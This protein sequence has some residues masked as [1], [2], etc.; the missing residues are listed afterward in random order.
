MEKAPTTLQFSSAHQSALQELR[1]CDYGRSAALDALARSAAAICETDLAAVM[2]VEAEQIVFAAMCG[3]SV[4]RAPRVTPVCADILASDEPFLVNDV[5]TDARCSQ[6][7]PFLDSLGVRA[8]AVTQIGLEPGVNV[9]AICVYD[10][11]PREW[12]KTQ[13]DALK[14]LSASAAELLRNAKRFETLSERNQVLRMSEDLA[15][16]GHW[17]LNLKNN[18][19]SWS[20]RVYDIHGVTRAEYAP[21]LDTAIDYYHPDDRDEIARLAKRAVEHGE[22]YSTRLRI[23]RPDGAVRVIET[24]GEPQTGPDGDVIA[25][26]GVFSDV[27]DVYQT[28]RDLEALVDTGH[29]GYWEWRATG[30]HRINAR[31]VIQAL[32]YECLHEE[33]TIED[34]ARHLVD[35]NLSEMAASF[36]AYLKSRREGSWSF[37]FRLRKRNGGVISVLSRGIVSE[38][39]AD[40]KPLRAVGTYTNIAQ[41]T[42]INEALRDS[43][44]RYALAVQGTSAGIWDC[45][46]IVGRRYNWSDQFYRLL[47]LEPGEIE[48]T[49]HELEKL[50]H[51]DDIE[52]GRQALAR[53]LSTGA[54]YSVR[55]RIFHKTLGYRWFHRTAQAKRDKNGAPTRMAGALTDIHDEVTA[56]IAAEKA[57]K[58]AERARAE[59]ETASAAKSSFLAMMS[60]E[61]RTPLNGVLGMADA[62]A[63]TELSETQNEMINTVISSG[64]I[65][66]K[67]LND[68]LD[69]SRM[70]AGKLDLESRE[71]NLVDALDAVRSLHEI[72]ANLR[73]LKFTVDI[74]PDAEGI[75]LGDVT[76]LQQVLNNLISNAIKF[77]PEGD[78]SLKVSAACADASSPAHETLSFTVADTGVGVPAAKQKELF[79]PFV[80]ADASTTRRFGGSGLGLAICKNLVELMGGKIW[81]ESAPGAGSTFGFELKLERASERAE[82]AAATVEAETSDDGASGLNVLVA[83]DNVANR[84]VLLAMLSAF[85]A[86]TTLVEDGA[87]AVEAFGAESYDAVLMDIQMPV[88]SGIEAVRRIREIE[89]ESGRPRARIIAVSA[90]TAPS[91]AEKCREAGMDEVLSKPISASA[92]H[93]ALVCDRLQA[94][95]GATEDGA[96]QFS[97]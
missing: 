12:T 17:R 82:R 20:D 36:G 28:R 49:A 25:I 61:I 35:G 6:P 45:T 42:E 81:V 60:H 1:A 7:T 62:L 39:A 77:T 27:T 5:A 43:E 56:R 75:Y 67:L 74:D 93:D 40:G 19:V 33:Q 11:R 91:D 16:V 2:L 26:F 50:I 22:P 47:G 95:P 73:G 3:F 37:E 38:R 24:C 88:M 51:P 4:E 48:P 52:A 89:A 41:F 78:V 44:E 85:G 66:M 55:S 23:V 59:A 58:D 57:R 8:V 97:I 53:H 76:R 94:D 29:D 34:L 54:P 9:G 64:R 84:S 46:D 65:L 79:A 83:D 70:E 69:V 68:V 10:R 63:N 31:R 32:G 15:N 92:L 87:A 90:S 30:D 14:S 71:F 80:Q 86:R 21:T 96:R 13:I 72:N 18:S